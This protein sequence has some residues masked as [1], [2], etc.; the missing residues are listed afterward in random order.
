MKRI[1]NNLLSYKYS[2]TMYEFNEKPLL[3]CL[4]INISEPKE[5]WNIANF[6][7]NN[8]FEMGSPEYDKG[9]ECLYFPRLVLDEETFNYIAKAVNV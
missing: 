3:F 6:C 4:G 2:V 9:L 7:R 1:I 5:I 8:F